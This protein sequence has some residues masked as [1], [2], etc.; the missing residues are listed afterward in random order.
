M[1]LDVVNQQ[2]IDTDSIIYITYVEYIHKV[3]MLGVLYG[4]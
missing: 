4:L 2:Y 3:E 1:T